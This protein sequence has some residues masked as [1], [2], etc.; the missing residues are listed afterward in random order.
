MLVLLLDDD[1]S[2]RSQRHLAEGGFALA[3]G[4]DEETG[5]RRIFDVEGDAGA[6][7]NALV[8]GELLESLP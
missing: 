3:D 4:G 2:G 1:S 8:A 7:F 6:V 5:V